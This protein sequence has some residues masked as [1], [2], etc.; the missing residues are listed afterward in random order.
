MAYI[1]NLVGAN[2]PKKAF[3][4]Y[5]VLLAMNISICFCMGLL[6]AGF[7]KQMAAFFAE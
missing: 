5:K 2:L 7:S 4:A 3:R 6:L 1:G